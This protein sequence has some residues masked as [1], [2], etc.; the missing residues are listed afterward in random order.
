[1]K[2]AFSEK[3]LGGVK[4]RKQKSISGAIFD[5]FNYSILTLFA[6]LAIGPFLHIAA[7]SLSSSAELAKR[8][9]VLFPVKPTLDAYHYIFTTN[10]FVRSLFNSIV[11]TISGTLV[12]I[13]LTSLTAYSLA[14]TR[15]IGRRTI[16]FL[17]T[18]T[19]LFGGGMIPTFILVK[20]LGL[21]DSYAALIIPGA[22]S[23]FNLIVLKNFFQQLPV[24]L[25]E[26]AKMD[27]ANDLMILLRIIYPLSLPALATFSLFYAVG[28]WN[29]YFSAI[30]YINDANKWPIQVLLR[31]IIILSNE[32][33]G[34]SD[35][36]GSSIV[37]PPESI[38][39]A[40]ILVA[41]VPILLVYPFLQKH[42][43]KGLLLGSVKG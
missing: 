32:G 33:I 26:S 1:M 25:E 34:D 17:I 36:V 16:M 30:L 29:T 8:G 41:T 19:I 35:L 20:N 28:H 6:L 14:H 43:T 39:M 7:G 12:N 37:I 13:I 21:I 38:K 27:G 22:I 40:V 3:L 15:I 2:K 10:T 9:F 18:F 4:V 5:V 31:Q 11:I 24:E 42:F 23:A